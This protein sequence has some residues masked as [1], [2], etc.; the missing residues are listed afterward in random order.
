MINIYCPKDNFERR[1]WIVKQTLGRVFKDYNLIPTNQLNWKIECPVSGKILNLADWVIP[2]CGQSK[3]LDNLSFV[4]IR[5]ATEKNGLCNELVALKNDR[6][7]K[8][9]NN[10]LQI[11]PYIDVLPDFFGM[12]FWHF[13][14][15]EELYSKDLVDIL[16]RHLAINSLMGKSNLLLR[17]VVDEWV[18]WFNKYFDNDSKFQNKI[19]C[20]NFKINLSHDVDIPFLFI[21]GGALRLCRTILGDLVKRKDILKSFGT[22]NAFIQVKMGN[23]DLDPMNTFEEL[24]TVAE[25]FNLQSTYHFIAGHSNPSFDGDYFLDSTEIVDLINS[26]KKRGHILGFHPSFYSGSNLDIMKTELKELI[27]HFDK[28]NL[29]QT[30]IGSRQHF[31]RFDLWQTAKQLEKLGIAY[32]ESLGYPDHVGF[33]CGTAHPYNFFDLDENRETSLEL[34]PLI[35][36]DVTILDKKYMGINNLEELNYIVNNLKNTLEKHGGN[37]SILWHNNQLDTLFKKQVFEKILSNICCR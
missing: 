2:K 4:N 10:Y 3:N 29:E 31:L 27:H 16:G 22:L 20:S 30:K 25:R 28:Q 13:T 1:S 23:Y 19:Q 34:R 37:M 9:R 15:W 33:R 26:I 14:R 11:D 36:M 12:A 18:T 6:G 8:T 21:N 32:D 35:L 24:M 7:K 17:P 5:L